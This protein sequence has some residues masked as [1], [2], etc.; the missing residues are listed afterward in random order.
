MQQ[1]PLDRIIAKDH[2]LDD[3]LDD[4]LTGNVDIAGA[5]AIAPAGHAFIGF[6][7]DQMGGAAEIVLLR[8]AQF[9][10]QVVL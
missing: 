1:S 9:L 2:R 4:G 7:L 6:D 8:I 5:K 3:F 10:G